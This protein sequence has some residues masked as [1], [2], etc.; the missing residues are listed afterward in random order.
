M[1]YEIT[2]IFNGRKDI[3][4]FVIPSGYTKIGSSAFSGCSSL[5][6]ITI[7]NTVIKIGSYAF[8]GAC[9]YFTYV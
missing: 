9:N 3:S 2:F 7:P 4:E 1:S 5:T 6:N 8:S